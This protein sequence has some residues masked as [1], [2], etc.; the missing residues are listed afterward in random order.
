MKIL[1]ALIVTLGLVGQ[2]AFADCSAF[3]QNNGPVEKTATINGDQFTLKANFLKK[4]IEPYG[5]GDPVTTHVYEDPTF[6]INGEEVLATRVSAQII[7]EEFGYE[8][9]E[10]AMNV[11][12]PRRIFRKALYLDQNLE[13]REASSD[14][15]VISSEGSIQPYHHECANWVY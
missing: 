12:A 14:T 7:F 3:P 13:V 5:G 9:I 8:H 10:H 1:A 15:I 2:T 11:R 6:Y 4:D